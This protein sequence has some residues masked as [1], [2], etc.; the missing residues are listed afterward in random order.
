MEDENVLTSESSCEKVSDYFSKNFSIKE[1]VKNKLIQE[2]I[3][4]DI[5]LGISKEDFISFGITKSQYLKISSYLKKNK[6]KFEEKEISEN[7]SS[8]STK[9]KIKEFLQKTLN[10]Q[11]NLSQLDEKEFLELDEE[12]M[13]K[14]GFNYGQRKRL[15]R[16]INYFIKL[17][18]EKTEVD[19]IEINI[20]EKSDKNEIRAFLKE[21][22]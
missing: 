7:L 6:D 4:G 3:T 11:G 20:T 22:I 14:F 19:D 18:D 8:I 5:L 17:K 9:E 2:S 10:F 16:Y 21:K 1:E 12:K 13:K 15:K